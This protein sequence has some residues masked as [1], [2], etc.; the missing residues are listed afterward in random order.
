MN[1]ALLNDALHFFIVTVFSHID[2]FLHVLDGFK[3]PDLLVKL[4]LIPL[5][6][7]HLFKVIL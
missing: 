7:D 1:F 3:I 2:I 5:L 4:G 6:D